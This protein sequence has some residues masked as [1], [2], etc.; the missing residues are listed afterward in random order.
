[1][2]FMK[3]TMILILVSLLA[4]CARADIWAEREALAKVASE[5]TAIEILVKAA[6]AKSHNAAR[7]KFDYEALLNDLN[8]VRAGISVHLT[9]PMEPVLPSLIVDLKGEYTEHEQ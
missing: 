9:S 6:K 2:N 4:P 5:L 1:M 3:T 7:A 8:T